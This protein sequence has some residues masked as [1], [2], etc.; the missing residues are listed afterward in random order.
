M[1]GDGKKPLKIAVLEFY[2]LN[3]KKGKNIQSNIQKKVCTGLQS[4]DGLRSLNP[5]EIVIENLD[6]EPEKQLI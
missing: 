4:I 1:D 6:S 5:L 3:S 2:K